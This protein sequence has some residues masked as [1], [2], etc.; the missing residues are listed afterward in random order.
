MPELSL[1]ALVREF[2]TLFVVIDP[3]GTL[4]V[5]YFATQGVPERLHWRIAVRAVLVAAGVLLLF[6]V[7]G[8]LLLE[9]L[10]LGLGSFQIAGGIILFL[11]AMT[12]I[13]GESKSEKEIEAAEKDHLAGAVYPLAMPSIASPG[14]M[15][16]V[17]ILTDN[18]RHS[19]HDQVITGGLLLLV[20]GVTLSVLLLASP[21]KRLIG[22]TGANIVSRVMG[23][24]LATV[25]VDSVL[26]GF[27]AVGVIN[28]T[29]Q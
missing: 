15:L 9:G 21:L 26:S 3:I 4:P 27:D 22:N 23:I 19:I 18:H 29:G 17:V 11:F 1:A 12:M 16:A 5:F 10:G 13:F 2:I 24:I 7:A 25:A 6:L 8:Q 28:V 20:L 14:A